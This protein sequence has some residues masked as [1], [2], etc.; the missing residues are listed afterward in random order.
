MMTNF[1][2]NNEFFTPNEI[3]DQCLLLHPQDEKFK[4]HPMI[5]R[6]GNPNFAMYFDQN[7]VEIGQDKFINPLVLPMYDTQLNLVQC[8]ILQVQQPIKFIPNSFSQGFSYCG[9][10]DPHKPIFITYNMMTYTAIA[11]SI[12]NTNSDYAVVLAILPT[13]CRTPKQCLD[14]IDYKQV[15]DVIKQLEKT[16]YKQIYIPVRPE[17][18][19]HQ[20]FKKIVENSEAILLNQS[21][22]EGEIEY[23]CDLHKD[24]DTIEIQNFLNM[25]THYLSA[26]TPSSGCIPNTSEDKI[27]QLAQLTLLEY[28]QTKLEKA[29]ALGIKPNILDKLVK[30]ERSKIIKQSELE[31][32]FQTV[33]PWEHPV[34]GI[35]L[36][37]SIEKTIDLHIACDPSTKIATALWILYTWAIDAMQIAPIACITAPEKRCGKTQLLT[38]IGELCYK[39]LPTSNIS[40]SAL[41]RAIDLWKPT[42]LIDEADTF[43]KNNEDLRSIINAG[44]SRKNAYAIRCDGDENKPTT[45]CVWGAKAICGIGRLPETIEDR[46][47]LLRLRRKLPNEKKQR[48]R[49]S[50]QAEWHDIRRMCLRWV[51]DN[52]ELIRN[53]YPILPNQLNDRAQDNWESL[54][55]I[56]HVAGTEWLE[57]ANQSALAINSFEMDTPNT[58][59]QLLSDIKHILDNMTDSKI[60]GDDLLNTLISDSEKI[61]ATYNYNSSLSRHQLTK[62]LGEFGVKSKDVNIGGRTKKGFELKQFKDAFLRYLP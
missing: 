45:F 47:I 7:N 42:L 49:H 33:Q 26:N 29:Q 34:N 25:A 38:L 2:D 3:L 15:I 32:L 48:L 6:F 5:E 9:K 23:F 50:N 4:S 62:K 55:K 31:K 36:L 41:Y 11:K 53:A 21:I 8:A 51:K 61:W 22:K 13:L 10:L 17:H 58:N 37:N 59:E 20:N 40:A 30:T 57:K 46:S 60:F 44:H 54:F 52:F 27:T 18:M 12:N 14:N 28:E 39:P 16:G 35:E 56:A 43:V 24:D 19:N 1:T